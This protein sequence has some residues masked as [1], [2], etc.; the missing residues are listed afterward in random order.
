MFL[1]RLSLQTD[2]GLRVLMFLA[3]EDR[4]CTVGE[5]AEFFSISR[6][7]VAK[8]VQTL[9]RLGFIRSIRGAGGGLELARAPENI[10]IGKVVGSLEGNMQ[11]LECVAA[12][13]CVCVIQPGCRLRHVLAEAERLQTE[14]LDSVRLS[15]VVTRGRRLSSMT[16]L[17]S[18]GK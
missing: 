2:Y 11:M 15:D 16:T 6:D 4:R 9:A 3:G 18:L 12:E 7:H 14:Y 17:E 5:I 13:R 8:V 10:S 1:M